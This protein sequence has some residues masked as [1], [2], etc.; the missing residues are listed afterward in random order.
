[1]DENQR[2]IMARALLGGGAAGQASDTTNL[3]QRWEQQN[4]QA[5]MNGQEFPSFDVWSQQ[6]M[7]PPTK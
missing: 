4:V 1:M 2:Q 6:F 5:Q 3:R 7:Q